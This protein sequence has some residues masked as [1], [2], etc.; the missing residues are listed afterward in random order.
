M[1]PLSLQGERARVRV[2]RGRRACRARGS[3]R[4][5]LAPSFQRKLES[6]SQV[7]SPSRTHGCEVPACAGTTPDPSPAALARGGLSRGERRQ[8]DPL[9][10]WERVRVR[11]CS[12][13]PAPAGIQGARAARAVHATLTRRCLSSSFPHRREPRPSNVRFVTPARC[14]GKLPFRTLSPT[15]RTPLCSPRKALLQIVAFPLHCRCIP[16]TSQ[17]QSVARSLQ[18]GRRSYEWSTPDATE[19]NRKQKSRAGLRAY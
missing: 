17:L 7:V 19:C 18:S 6:R 15:A 1:D 5:A 11:G 9:S 16:S 13:I 10:L 8:S 12:V 2:L 3:L 4:R 14:A